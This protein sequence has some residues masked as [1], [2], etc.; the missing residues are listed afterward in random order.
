MSSQKRRAQ[1]FKHRLLGWA[2]PIAARR[3]VFVSSLAA[4]LRGMQSSDKELEDK[5][6][7][8]FDLA[9]TPSTLRLPMQM[10]ARIWAKL[11][12][13]LA[14]NENGTAATLQ[15]FCDQVLELTPSYLVYGTQRNMRSD[16]FQLLREIIPSCKKA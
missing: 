5:L 15:R 11:D 12:N 8:L 13:P 4:F 7:S 6:T 1:P 2:L 16:V 9:Y 3:A 10:H 14:E